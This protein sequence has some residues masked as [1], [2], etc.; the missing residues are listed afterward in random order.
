MGQG[1]LAGVAEGNDQAAGRLSHRGELHRSG[2]C[3]AV[4]GY[5]KAAG[6]GEP[7]VVAESRGRWGRAAAIRLPSNAV[8]NPDAHLTA[9]S[10]PKAGDCVAVGT[11]TATSN[12]GEA[13]AVGQRKGRWGRATEIQLPKVNVEPSAELYSV[14]CASAGSCIA[15]GSYVT[16]SNLIAALVVKESGGRWKRGIHLTALPAN[17]AGGSGQTANL[18]GV[19]CT[20]SSCLAVGQYADTSGGELAMAVSES[21]GKWARAAEAG[22]PSH[23][24]GGSA[25]QADL[26][27]VACLH[28]GSCTA[29]GDYVSSSAVLEAMA[30][31][32]GR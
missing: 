25:Q 11:Y 24:A 30:A 15:V 12:Q 19:S 26:F 10:C 16:R 27:A 14:S 6:N 21:R 29:V 1:F 5:T 2:T 17:A 18:N 28:G 23:A 13:M 32:R 8:A 31:S 20:A 3:V 22:P 7:M 4:G 9:V